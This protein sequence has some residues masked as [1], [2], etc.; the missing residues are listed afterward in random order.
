MA[1]ASPAF[2]F[3]RSVRSKVPKGSATDAGTA[4]SLGSLPR[5]LH[6]Q[7]AHRV[8]AHHEEQSLVVQLATTKY[9]GAGY[10]SRRAATHSVFYVTS[11]EKT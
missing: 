4:M 11:A 6:T 7:F 9:R 3:S 8:V 1:F 2:A 10:G 5:K